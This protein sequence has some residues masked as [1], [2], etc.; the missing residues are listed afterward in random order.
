MSPRERICEIYHC[1]PK[2]TSME[3]TKI[4]QV[5]EILT[6]ILTKVERIES[7]LEVLAKDPLIGKDEGLLT[8]S[9]ASELLNLAISTLYSKVSR[10]EIPVCKRGNRLYFDRAEILEWVRSGRVKTIEE[11]RKEVGGSR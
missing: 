9:Q 5:P 3:I 2:K 10:N 11:I 6:M 4:E 8:V 1:P 7:L